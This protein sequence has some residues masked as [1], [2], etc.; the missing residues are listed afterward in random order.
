M[1]YVK[2]QVTDEGVTNRQK[3]RLIA[4]TTAMLSEVL[5]KEPATT[6]V[7]IEEVPLDNWGISGLPVSEFR[8]TANS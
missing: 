8:R 1:P 7:V 5:D 4:Q 2:I 3:Q 6:F